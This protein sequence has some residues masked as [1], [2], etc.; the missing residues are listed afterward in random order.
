[1]G[2]IRF[3]DWKTSDFGQRAAEGTKPIG[4]RTS[5]QSIIYSSPVR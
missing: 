2:D 4:E 1:M 5:G 3:V